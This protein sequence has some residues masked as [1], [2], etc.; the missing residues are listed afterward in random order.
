M[1]VP[2][3]PS[4]FWCQL[5]KSVDEL[6]TMMEKLN[7]AYGSLPASDMI[8]EKPEKGMPCVA[9]Y[10]EDERWYRGE[11]VS[12]ADEDL[13][14]HFVDYGNSENVNKSK[15][16][17]IKPEFMKLPSQSVKCCLRGLKPVN[18]SWS[19]KAVEEF[20]GLTMDKTLSLHVKSYAA[21]AYIVDLE[22]KEG[23]VDVGAK[24]VELGYCELQLPESPGKPTKSSVANPFPSLDMSEGEKFTAFVSWVENPQDFWIQPADK[25]SELEELGAKVQDLYSGE[26]GALEKVEVGLPVI[27]QFSED[28]AW[29]RAYIEAKKADKL[30]VRFVDYGNTDTLG[31]ESLRQPSEELLKVPAQALNC[32]LV[33]IRPLQSTW[34]SDSKDIMEEMVKDGATVHLKS[35]DDVW[36][37]DMDVNGTSVAEEL[38]TA[39]VVR[40]DAPKTP[41]KTSARRLIHY[42]NIPQIP[43]GS[44][45]KVFVSHV[46]SL[47]SFY[48]QMSKHSGELD[49]V[50]AAIDEYCTSGGAQGAGELK[51]STPCLAQYSADGGWYRATVLAVYPEEADVLFIDYGNRE[52]VKQGN[53][54]VIKDEFLDL[55]P[56]AIH[57]TFGFE[58]SKE[59]MTKLQ[60]LVA[61]KEFT[62]KAL[63][64][65]PGKTT[66]Y[67]TDEKGDDVFSLIQGSETPMETA[68]SSTPIECEGASLPM[69]TGGETNIVKELPSQ[70]L[71]ID[72]VTMYASSIDSPSCLYLQKAGIEDDL[73]TISQQL[74]SKYSSLQPSELSLSEVCVGS[75]CCAKYSD[76]NKWYRAKIQSIT[77]GQ[78]KVVFVDYGNGEETDTASLKALTSDFGSSPMAY[79]C[80]LADVAPVDGTWSE[81]A[82]A[83]FDESVMEQELECCF[84]SLSE[85]NIKVSNTDIAKLMIEKGFAIKELA[86]DLKFAEQ[87]LPE[88]TLK[89]SVSHLENDIFYLQLEKDEEAIGEI[90]EILLEKCKSS[91]SC[92]KVEVGMHCC[93][94]FNVDGYWYRAQV[95]NVSEKDISVHF[96][97]YGNSDSVT[98]ENIRPLDKTILSAPMAYKCCL[99]RVGQLTSDQIQSLRTLIEEQEVMVQFSGIEDGVYS[100]SLSKMDGK[101]IAAE[102]ESK[103]VEEDKV[104]QECLSESMA[105]LDI[106][107]DA[108]SKS[109]IVN[110]THLTLDVT[111]FSDGLNESAI[112]ED[113][114]EKDLTEEDFM[115]DAADLVPLTLKDGDR[116]QVSLSHV[117]SPSSFYIHQVDRK[118][119]I[120]SLLDEIFELYSNTTNTMYEISEP[121]EGSLAVALFSEDS[122]W[123]RTKIL[124]ALDDIEFK[125]KF[126]DYGNTEVCKQTD[127]RKLLK[128]FGSQPLQTVECTLGGVRAKDGPWSEEAMALFTEM[129]SDKNL[130]MDVVKVGDDGNCIVQLLDMGLSL[131]E[132]LIDKGHGVASTTP[133]AVSQKTKRVFSDS[134]DVALTPLAR[135]LAEEIQSRGKNNYGSFKKIQIEPD[136]E[137]AVSLCHTENPG[138]FWCQ[139]SDTAADLENMLDRIQEVYKEETTL[140][141]ADASEGASC[142]ALNKN[143]GLFY[144]AVVVSDVDKDNDSVD[145]FYVDQGSTLTVNLSDLREMSEEFMVLPAQSTMCRLASVVPNHGE[146]WSE[147]ACKLFDQLTDDKDDLTVYVEQIGRDGAAWVQLLHGEASIGQSLVEE[148]HAVLIDTSMLED[149]NVLDSILE[150]SKI[151][152]SMLE[153]SAVPDTSLEMSQMTDSFLDSGRDSIVV[154]LFKHYGKPELLIDTEYFCTVSEVIS[155]SLF[156]TH[157]R[158]SQEN[159]RKI[160]DEIGEVTQGELT[161]PERGCQEGIACLCKLETTGKYA[162]A[163]VMG[164]GEDGVQV[165]YVD[166]GKVEVVSSCDIK[167][168]PSSLLAPP[169]QAVPCGLV[170]VQSSDGKAWSTEVTQF[171][172]DNLEGEVVMYVRNVSVDGIHLVAVG[173]Q[174]DEGEDLNKQMVDLGLAKS[175]EDISMFDMNPTSEQ[176]ES[177]NNLTMNRMNSYGSEEFSDCLEGQHNTKSGDA[178]MDSGDRADHSALDTTD[179]SFCHCVDTSMDTSLDQS[180]TDLDKTEPY[181]ETTDSSINQSY[182]ETTT[183]TSVNDSVADTTDTSVYDTSTNE[184]MSDTST[185]TE[186][187]SVVENTDAS[188]NQSAIET[189]INE[190]TDTCPADSDANTTTD[191]SCLEN[192]D[193]SG[194][195]TTGA[196]DS[197]HYVN[198]LKDADKS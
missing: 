49:D 15:V 174:N 178:T 105:E 83:L 116:L 196:S 139:L 184:P 130:L 96:V 171:V 187:D 182:D 172:K 51:I 10:S 25:E 82:T 11:I 88:G 188:M 34:N 185:S 168:L 36:M 37:V 192:V 125:V 127:L 111:G 42:K 23:D 67:L 162:R 120:D 176:E 71:P 85:V 198:Y 40:R 86:T 106:R 140:N 77:D 124:E 93:A 13:E 186:N 18:N 108:A 19:D 78:A 109:L 142:I 68:V 76:D 52:K 131:S 119:E 21:G 69:E 63:N 32:S 100:V 73:E 158:K 152:D 91:P 159:L 161:G 160:E 61:D 33:G 90:G 26:T 101:D 98:K 154:K 64:V 35:K 173:K 45:E 7:A 28:D 146:K 115:T 150:D 84:K 95:D 8:V 137:Y 194:L 157:L 141:L 5:V 163:T 2:N 134:S 165:G 135:K 193:E 97:D 29:Y 170:G 89:A 113:G 118:A 107:D 166:Y 104:E 87:S 50:M 156:F 9:M 191:A 70:E 57:C 180:Q 164:V 92:D 54:Y 58:G 114:E 46:N 59:T 143:D 74:E 14:V 175:Q 132:V 181:A 153:S 30:M 44:S 75:I 31:T 80:S 20:E 41:E 136:T 38:I 148:D 60:D 39:A 144:R 110:D 151:S 66:V 48:C 22:D 195:E 94:K 155:P 123:Y 189:S 65:I 99:G 138:L 72:T 122:S 16:K 177:F 56:Q 43:E 12:I 6:E 53:I 169:A 128:K 79:E 81:E 179:T 126:L 129:T 121:E 145:V 112:K 147:E 197:F 1:F 47:D 24:M 103:P 55:E 190:T 3:N 27:A 183:D 133:I 117:N 62:V 149:S 167:E 102:L 17:A 4:E